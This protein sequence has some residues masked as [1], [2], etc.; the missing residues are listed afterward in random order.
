MRLVQVSPKPKDNKRFDTVEYLRIMGLGDKQTVQMREAKIHGAV[1]V[2]KLPP[3]LKTKKVESRQREPVIPVTP[4]D[5]SEER[6][7]FEELPVPK[8]GQPKLRIV[9]RINSR[10]RR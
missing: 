2:K 5:L 8:P 4:E 3:S 1:E 6:V 9:P 7:E 10:R